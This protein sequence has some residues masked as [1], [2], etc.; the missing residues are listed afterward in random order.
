MQ[1]ILLSGNSI[2]EQAEKFIIGTTESGKSFIFK[3]EMITDI[4]CCG[5]VIIIDMFNIMVPFS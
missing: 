5:D 4:L 3:R 2:K 1:D